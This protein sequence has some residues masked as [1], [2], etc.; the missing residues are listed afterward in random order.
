MAGTT[1]TLARYDDVPQNPGASGIG[2]MLMLAERPSPTP[3]TAGAR[4]KPKTA[5]N[6]RMAGWNRMSVIVFLPIRPILSV[7][8]G[9]FGGWSLTICVSRRAWIDD[10][11]KSL[12]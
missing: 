8:V 4:G 5:N 11:P 3:Y 1:A 10:S 2:G 9:F 6:D 12:K 7:V